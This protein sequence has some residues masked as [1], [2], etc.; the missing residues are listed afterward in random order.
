MVRHASTRYP[1]A[2]GCVYKCARSLARW[3]TRT[4]IDTAPRCHGPNLQSCKCLCAGHA[5]R[6]REISL[7]TYCQAGHVHWAARAWTM[8]HAAH[9]RIS[10][11]TSIPSTHLPSTQRIFKR[12]AKQSART[13]IAEQSQLGVTGVFV[14]TISR[15][16]GAPAGTCQE[17]VRACLL[18][19]LLG[20]LKP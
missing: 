19:S 10:A 11:C 9:Q 5:A 17:Q 3:Y 13:L 12:V 1:N 14:A 2:M 18:A 6:I 20:L 16:C 8:R 15:A 7:A 4:V